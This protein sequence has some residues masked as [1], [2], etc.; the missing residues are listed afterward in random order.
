MAVSKKGAKTTRRPPTVRPEL[1]IG[2]IRAL[3]ITN[4]PEVRG[5]KWMARGVNPHRDAQD[6]PKPY[7]FLDGNKG[8]PKGFGFYVGARGASYEVSKRGA[9]GFVRFSLGSVND[10]GLDEAYEEARKKLG[11]L[12]ETGDNP[13]RKAA[14][15]AVLSNRKS[16]TVEACFLALIEDMTWRAKKKQIKAS[17]VDGVRDSLA[18]L[19]RPEVGLAGMQV[20]D[21]TEKVAL[22]AF[23]TLRL[24]AMKR[25]NRIPTP[26]R[27][28]LAK[29]KDWQTLSPEE[30]ERLGITGKYVPRVQAAGLAAAEHTMG[31][32]I[33]AIDLVVKQEA[34]EAL[35]QG[36]S[37]VL[38]ANPLSVLIEKK[39]F[40][41]A[42]QLRTHYKNAKVRNPLGVED[43][44]LPRVLKT[45]VARRDEQGGHNSAAADYLLLTL[46]FG[47]RRSEAARLKWYDRCTKTELQQKLASW[48]WLSDDENKVNP[49]T[50]KAGSQAY[51][52]D[53]KSGEERHIPI[54]Y[55]ARR[56]LMR[57]L[58][59][60]DQL[61]TE[62]PGRIKAAEQRLR[63]V[64]KTTEDYRKLGYAQ[65]QVDI[66]RGRTD[67]LQWVF[68]ARSHKAKSGHYSD[69]KSIL[70]NVRRDAGLVDLDKEIDIGLTP[71]DLRR[72]LGRFAAK[73]RSGVIVS[74]M[75]H[76]SVPEK[77]EEMAEVSKLYTEQE[78][79]DLR[80]AFAEV[81]E[82]M[83]AT[84]PRVWNRLKGVD[85]PRLDEANDPP[86]EIF[87]ARK[88]V[89]A[90][91]AGH[92]QD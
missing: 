84:S 43:Q 45:I 61:A 39:A 71:H 9:N 52:H 6:R 55:F 65:R 31:D 81:E 83:I 28:A 21:I 50:G 16:I 47:A 33:R 12:K 86:A 5:K 23:E 41:S 73:L 14:L 34:S 35:S 69:S 89:E 59:E 79:G 85:K 24:S 70:R 87:L 11:V 82:A 8:A 62:I 17:S 76:H 90:V 10:M 57:R 60:R 25:S 88:Q 18:R 40:R 36:R 48:V 30:L 66:E 72:T 37:P 15:D 20:R 51:F 58:A 3:D 1:S 92:R 42:R 7:R 44:T 77:G 49:L 46:L 4:F 56:I 22:N 19:Q 91:D 27:D 32:A 64:K 80:E 29:V 38:F 54:S 2:E 67:R 53:T 13:K 26:M 75:L 68:P 78:W 74:Q 63:E